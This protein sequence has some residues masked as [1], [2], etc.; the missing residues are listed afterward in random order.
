MSIN[1]IYLLLTIDPDGDTYWFSF[2]K[3]EAIMAYKTTVEETSPGNS[4]F[5][6]ECE[7][8]VDMGFD[9]DMDFYGGTILMEFRSD[10]E[11]E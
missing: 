6:A 11:E 9:R 7:P 2:D 10:E 3:D 5:L 1:F 8:G 4:V